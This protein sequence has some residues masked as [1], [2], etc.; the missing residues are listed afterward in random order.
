MEYPMALPHINIHGGRH[1]KLILLILIFVIKKEKMPEDL[2]MS[3]QWTSY[4]NRKQIFILSSSFP[5]KNLRS[6]P[7]ELKMNMLTE[8]HLLITDLHI[9]R[10]NKTGNI[11]HE[12]R[13]TKPDK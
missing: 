12:I 10:I 1:G 8:D 9:T 5:M 6:G 3:C 7:S 4:T 11:D 2:T 13:D